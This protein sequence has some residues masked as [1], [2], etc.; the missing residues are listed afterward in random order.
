M[1]FRI[2]FSLPLS[3]LNLSLAT[4]AS[5]QSASLS[6]AAQPAQAPGISQVLSPSFAGL[7]LEPSNLYSFTGASSNNNLTSNLLNTLIQ[8]SG[9]P[10]TFRIG[11]NTGDYMIYDES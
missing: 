5:A 3:L 4:V 1:L 7:S 2:G 6:P 9:A 10:P 11:S 8:Y